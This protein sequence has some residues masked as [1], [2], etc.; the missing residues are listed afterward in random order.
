M[1]IKL[2]YSFFSETS[3]GAPYGEIQLQNPVF[4]VL[5]AIRDQ[6]SI[7]KAASALGFSYRYMWGFLKK[8]EEAFGHSLLASTQGQA[9]RLSD[10][11]ER[12]LWAE[13]KMLARFLPEAESLAAKLDRELLLAV[14]PDLRLLP[15]FGSH[16]LLFPALRDRLQRH[17]RVL[18]DIGYVSSLQALE[19]LNDGACQLAGIHLPLEDERLCRRGSVI[20]LALGRQLRLADHKLIRFVVRE[21]GLMVAPGNPLGLS[22]LSDLGRDEVD[23]VNRAEGSGTRL[24][25]DELLVLAGMSAHR[26]A[27]YGLE[28]PTHMSVAASVAAGHANCGF[29]LRAAAERFGLGFV[30][31]VSEQYFLVC[32]KEALESEVTQA[33]LDVLRSD[34]FSR[35]AA[36]VPG[37]TAAGS[38]EIV[39]LRRTLPWYR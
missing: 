21:Q 8:Q 22:G 12:L 37:Y 14:E 27:G 15:V 26:I 18:L 11:G 35:L 5:A 25:L 2:N 23:F 30:P 3:P 32:R 38:G 39:S 17:A 29:G 6:G 7:G 4:E 19:K 20:H 1:S 9:A 24:L 34:D 31:L 28:E 33:V 10:F 13:K 16:D 36:A